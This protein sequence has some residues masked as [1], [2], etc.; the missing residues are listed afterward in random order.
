M[1][2]TMLPFV[3]GFSG[4]G[5]VLT[6]SEEERLYST[7]SGVLLRNILIWTEAPYLTVCTPKNLPRHGSLEVEWA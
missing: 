7:D 2:H 6:Y 5:K 3:P 4:I 1:G